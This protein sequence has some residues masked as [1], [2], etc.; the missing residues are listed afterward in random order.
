M[1][2]VLLFVTSVILLCILANRFS[3]KLGMP[4]LLLFMALGMLFGSDGIVKISFDN[5]EV[6]EKICLVALMF[7]IFY[8][9]FGTKWEIAKPVAVKSLAVSTVGTLVTALL[10]CGFCHFVLHISFS[11]SFLIG[12]VISSTDAASVFSILRSKNLDLKYGTA[13]LLELESGS[14]DPVAY[15]L[16][17]M[18]LAFLKGEKIFVPG[19]LFTQ[20]VFGILVGVVVAV[21]GC[22][23]IEKT[24]ILTD[25]FDTIFV[26]AIVIISYAGADVIQGNGFL[27]VYLTG[28]IMGNHKLKNKI[29]LVHF[30]DALTGMAQIALFFLLGLLSFPHKIITVLPIALAVALFL[31][32]VARPIAMIAILKPLKCSL[33]QCILISCAGLRGAASIVFAIMAISHGAVLEND[34]YHIVFFISLFSVSVQGSLLAFV[35]KK[36]DMIEEGGNILKTFTDYQEESS[37]TM[38]RIFIPEG[39]HWINKEI[40]EVNLPSGSLALMIKRESETIIPKGDT[41]VQSGDSVILSVPEYQATGEISLKEIQIDKFHDWNGKCIADLNLPDDI[42]IAMLKRGEENII[43]RGKTTIQ[44]NDIVVIYD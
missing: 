22:L 36:L 32:F 30:F 10:T 27:S 18:G 12:A 42:L 2:S 43:P 20:I 26:I 34:L 16:T 38:V 23:I 9:G 13:S 17:L 6:T 1:A 11:E 37:I 35:A 28:I 7:I 44:E 31:T 33:K 41:V 29:S 8:G 4:A 24:N 14:N 15:M 19:M 5:Y 25:G 3:D 39:H 40:S 21:V